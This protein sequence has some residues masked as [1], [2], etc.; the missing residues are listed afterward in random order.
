M[1]IYG[2]IKR[3]WLWVRYGKNRKEEKLAQYVSEM[4]E[5]ENEY[6]FADYD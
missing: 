4:L 3:L 6:D 1:G 2:L 5:L